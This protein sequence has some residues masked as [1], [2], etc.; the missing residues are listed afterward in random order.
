MPYCDYETM[1]DAEPATRI[2]KGLY[3]GSKD[4][5]D[6]GDFDMV[7]SAA[8]EWK[9]EP[10]RGITTMYVPLRDVP[11]DFERH[12]NELWSL[13]DTSGIIADR[14][15]QGDKVFIFCNMGMNRSGLL[16]ALT[17]LHLGATPKSAIAAVRRRHPCTLSN[18]S[19]ARAI[20]YAR[21]HK[22]V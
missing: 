2:R 20:E 5:V 22:M 3:M 16:T 4:G 15:K 1:K 6:S 18:E 21:A 14:I 17:L 9:A 8:E 12:E 11:F 10:K 7:V 19:F 13:V